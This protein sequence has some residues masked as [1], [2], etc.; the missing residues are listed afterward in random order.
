[1]IRECNVLMRNNLVMVVDFDG[2]KVQMPTDNSEED[3]IYVE[4][5]NN[6]FTVT[7]K[8]KYDNFSKPVKKEKAV[9]KKEQRVIDNE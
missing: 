8:D 9:F 6:K 1:M 5:Q 3:K 7:S 2:K 4:L